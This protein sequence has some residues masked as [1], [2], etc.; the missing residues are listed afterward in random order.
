[1]LE[2]RKIHVTTQRDRSLYTFVYFY[3]TEKCNVPRETTERGNFTTDA[4]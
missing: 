2:N 3:A 1:M 4:S